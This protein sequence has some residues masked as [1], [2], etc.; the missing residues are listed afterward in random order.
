MPVLLLVKHKYVIIQ[1]HGIDSQNNL[2]GLQRMVRKR[3]NIQRAEAAG[4]NALMMSEVRGEQ[5]DWLER[6][7]Q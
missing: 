2:S 5:P 3:V 1:S 4:E 7:K 6:R